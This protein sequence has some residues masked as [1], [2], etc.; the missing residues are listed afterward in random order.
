MEAA[1]QLQRRR[2]AQGNIQADHRTP[3]ERFKADKAYHFQRLQDKVAS[4]KVMSPAERD[5]YDDL[6]LNMR[7]E[8]QSQ[9]R[10]KHGWFLTKFNP[11]FS[12]LG[13]FD[14]AAIILLPGTARPQPVEFVN[15]RGRPFN[16]PQWL[17]Q[18]GV[19]APVSSPLPRSYIN[20]RFTINMAGAPA[21]S[22]TNAAGFARNGPWF[23]RQ[24]LG[25]HP[26][27]FSAANR[28]AIAAG[29]SPVV[30][31]T[32][33]AQNPTHQSFMGSRL[34]HHHIEQGAIATGLP[35]PVH[36]AWHSILHP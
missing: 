1:D 7:I 28:T 34:I 36:R 25:Q 22:A 27:L 32:W 17:T 21:G 3:D 24:M 10:D 12:Q 13:N 20:S 18:G 5:E 23:W 30:D 14:D 4:G 33:V 2:D 6:V 19:A 35:E 9:F 29:R 26:E 11:A 15:I 16:P 31:A 8:E